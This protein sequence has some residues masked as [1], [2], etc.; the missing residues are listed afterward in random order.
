VSRLAS[1]RAAESPTVARKRLNTRISS[2]LKL[3]KEYNLLFMS[4]Y[5][6]SG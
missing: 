1:Y 4:F 6:I 3:T 5:S 2:A